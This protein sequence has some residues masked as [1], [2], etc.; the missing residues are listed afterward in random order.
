V[1]LSDEIREVITSSGESVKAIST[2]T[3]IPQPT[4]MWFLRG[5]ELRISAAEKICWYLGLKLEIEAS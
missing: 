5:G 1:T 2:A 3:G 4:I